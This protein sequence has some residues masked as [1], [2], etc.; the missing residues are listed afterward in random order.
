MDQAQNRLA[1]IR[2][3]LENDS[4]LRAALDQV[5]MTGTAQK[6]SERALR[7]AES[8]ARGQ[9]IKIEQ[10]ES[11]LYG[12]HVH[13]PK[14]LQDLQN[15][16]A[17]LKRHLTTLEERQLNLMLEVESAQAALK[18]A[19]AALGGIQSRRGDEHRHL[20]EE[21]VTLS[22]TVERLQSERLAVVSDIAS[23]PLEIYDQL[24]QQKRG[25]AVVEVADDAC[26]ACGTTL[27]AALQQS[28]RSAT[29]MSNCPSC[30]RILFAS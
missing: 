24:R 29:Q 18:T 2:K 23:Q 21:Q 9:Q 1:S 22:K 4:E 26:S 30:G 17:S 14:E 6:E 19:E 13:N 11:S 12:G 3:T 10:S 20:I 5:E 15:E 16:I 25:I 8:Q 28:A 7:E 27:N